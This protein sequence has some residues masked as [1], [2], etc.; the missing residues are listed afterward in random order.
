MW[1]RIRY[2][3]INIGAYC[4]CP[5]ASW[6]PKNRWTGSPGPGTR[7]S[8]R[9]GTRT[10]G[11]GAGASAWRSGWRWRTWTTTRPSWWT[12]NRTWW[13]CANSSR[14]AS[15]WSPSRRPTRTRATTPRSRIPYSKVRTRA[16]EERLSRARL[17]TLAG[18]ARG[19]LRRRVVCATR[20]D[21]LLPC[22]T[23]YG[24]RDRQTRVKTI[25]SLEA[26]RFNEMFVWSKKKKVNV[27]E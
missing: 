27:N 14:P 20:N 12:R 18:R 2:V 4:L 5:Q 24:V 21:I 11:S 6:A 15:R 13:P 9:P 1:C 23:L 22:T 16:A 17:C 7:W 19:R 3:C 10:A 25:R 26:W 8:S